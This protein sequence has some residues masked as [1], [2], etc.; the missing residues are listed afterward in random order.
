MPSSNSLISE[1]SECEHTSSSEG[2]LA[3]LSVLSLLLSAQSLLFLL[4]GSQ[5]SAVSTVLLL[6]QIN[7]SVLLL[8]ELRSCRVSA[9]LAEDGEDL[10]NVLSHLLD[11][12][13]FDLGLRRDLGHAQLRESFLQQ[14]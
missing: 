8:F 12:G 13:Q 14:R 7:G 2:V 5:L 9:L 1:K 3:L 10:G 6:S 11:H 4:E